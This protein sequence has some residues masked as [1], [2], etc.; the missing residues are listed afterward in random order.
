MHSQLFPHPLHQTPL[1]E[2]LQF[3]LFVRSVVSDIEVITEV[4]ENANLYRHHRES[5]T[6]S[7]LQLAKAL[8]S[9]AGSPPKFGLFRRALLFYFLCKLTKRGKYPPQQSFRIQLH[10]I[11]NQSRQ[12]RNRCFEFSRRR[13]FRLNQF[14]FDFL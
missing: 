13:N 5:I 1:T 4:V 8:L 14:R 11:E 2:P 7:P 10:L 9:F 6:R 12:Q 3:G